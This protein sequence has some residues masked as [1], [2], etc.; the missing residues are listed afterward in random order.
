MALPPG[1]VAAQRVE[2]VLAQ[3]LL[4]HQLDLARL[5]RVFKALELVCQALL[6]LRAWRSGLV[7]LGWMEW[8]S[9]KVSGGTY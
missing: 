1:R 4:G 9:Y 7:G 2:I 3:H 6:L 8:V 5:R